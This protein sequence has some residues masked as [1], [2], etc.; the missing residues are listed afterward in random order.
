MKKQS[1]PMLYPTIRYRF[2]KRLIE[3]I[4]NHIDHYPEHCQP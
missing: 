1:E 2:G 4:M 3:I